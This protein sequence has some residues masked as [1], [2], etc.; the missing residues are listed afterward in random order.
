MS[1]RVVGGIGFERLAQRILSAALRL[2]RPVHKP[3]VKV[4]A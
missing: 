2:V 4:Q 1:Y 3:V